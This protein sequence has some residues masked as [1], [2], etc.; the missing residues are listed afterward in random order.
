MYRRAES[1]PMQSQEGYMKLE[2]VFGL[3]LFLKP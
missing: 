1:L 2:E 3:A